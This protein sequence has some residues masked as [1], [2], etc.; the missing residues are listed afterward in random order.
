MQTQTHTHTHTHTHTPSSF[1]NFFPFKAQ[2]VSETEF[3][4]AESSVNATRNTIRAIE[5]EFFEPF[6]RK[7][8]IKG[9]LRKYDEAVGRLQTKFMNSR[10][11]LRQQRAKLE[12]QLTYENGRDFET[13][14]VA[15]ESSMKSTQ[16]K[17]DKSIAEEDKL[18][19]KEEGM[20]T[21]LREAKKKLSEYTKE[22]KNLEKKFIVA[23]KEYKDA[24]QDMLNVSKSV[25]AEDVRLERKRV[26][27]HEC[28][29]KAR[30]EKVDLPRTVGSRKHSPDNTY[31]R[32][33]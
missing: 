26:K 15:L 28:L 23:Q 7:H 24:Q 33:H 29:Q 20:K 30:V 31:H 5:K 13:P 12:A 18:K 2:A 9:D 25:T 32:F 6:A 1:S 19:K 10:T 3:T 14:V 8:K 27:L 17:L 21:N 16:E 11:L 4:E 22:E